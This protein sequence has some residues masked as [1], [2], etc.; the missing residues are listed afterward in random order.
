MST[1]TIALETSVYERL[2]RHKRASESFT[3]TINRLLETSTVTGTCA[4]AVASAARIWREN[5]NSEE[6]A[7]MEQ[8]IRDGRSQVNWDVE[9]PS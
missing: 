8:L 7:V 6:A 2:A 3:K 5:G 9:T 4:D 1:K